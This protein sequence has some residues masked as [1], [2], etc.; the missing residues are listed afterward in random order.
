MS[1][2]APS[3]T[4]RQPNYGFA[5]DEGCQLKAGHGDPA[6]MV[7]LT[8]TSTLPRLHQTKVYVQS[9][10][11][12]AY[13]HVK[14]KRAS[15][16]NNSYELVGNLQGLA[17]VLDEKRHAPRDV[18]IRGGVLKSAPKKHSRTSKP[19]ARTVVDVAR[20][21]VMVD[22]DAA[23]AGESVPKNWM[24]NPEAAVRSIVKKHLPKAFHT[25]GVVAHWSSGM[26]PD[27]GTPKVHL[28]FM[29]SR[30]L[31][32]IE[33]KQWLARE[34]HEKK[35]DGALFQPVQQHFTADPQYLR[36]DDTPRPDLL[37]DTRVTLVDGPDVGVPDTFAP[38]TPPQHVTGGHQSDDRDRPY[39]NLPWRDAVDMTGEGGEGYHVWIRDVVIPNY[40]RQEDI[41]F[42]A[43]LQAA[44]QALPYTDIDRH[45][46][47][48]GPD[49]DELWK[50]FLDFVHRKPEP[51][52]PEDI[53]RV[54]AE[55]AARPVM[56][57]EMWEAHQAAAHAQIHDLIT[58]ILRP[59]AK[60]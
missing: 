10:A 48:T 51:I 24:S 57:P 6:A 4:G 56:T 23:V 14:G 31:Y 60:K 33:V 13:S 35:I 36:H 32:S 28:Y 41:P 40:Y 17:S 54:Q 52:S 47:R 21:W 29:L 43:E 5:S 53:A 46:D 26:S 50:S 20:V 19:A 30:P 34:T 37:G 25:A 16:F 58:N 18:L 42:K 22:V 9:E 12:G 3:I 45:Y 2:R 55:R 38:F 49:F 11:G 8:V 44:L 39:Y 15:C 27:G 7:F 1:I 59:A